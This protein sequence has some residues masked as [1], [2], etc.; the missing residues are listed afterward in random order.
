MS[1]S[2][3]ERQCILKRR[4]NPSRLLSVRLRLRMGWFTPARLRVPRFAQDISHLRNCVLVLLYVYDG[5]QDTTTYF[6]QGP[7]A[8]DF[9][10]CLLRPTVFPRVIPSSMH[11]RSVACSSM[12]A[13]RYGVR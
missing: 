3:R 1:G 7:V 6:D 9:H 10:G 8:H 13:V 4:L 2:G 12:P 5:A 11:P